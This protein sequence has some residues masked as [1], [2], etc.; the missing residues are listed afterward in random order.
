MSRFSLWQGSCIQSACFSFITRSCFH[1]CQI[2]GLFDY[3]KTAELTCT[4]LSGEME[5]GPTKTPVHFRGRSRFTMN[6]TTL[7]SAVY[8]VTRAS[9]EFSPVCLS[10]S[11]GTIHLVNSLKNDKYVTLDGWSHGCRI[12]DLYNMVDDV[13][14]V[15]VQTA[16]WT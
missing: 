3:R 6:L 2:V 11:L 9:A 12:F 7:K 5:D 10:G 14:V 1:L 4:E 8:C 13:T 16:T 15:W